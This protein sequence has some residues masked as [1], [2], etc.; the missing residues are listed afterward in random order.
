[1]GCLWVGKSCPLV[2]G[3]TLAVH[4]LS[5]TPKTAEDLPGS[6]LLWCEV[7]KHIAVVKEVASTITRAGA[8]IPGPCLLWALVVLG[9]HLPP[10]PH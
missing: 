1:M 8:A 7:S 10:L 3:S 6:L 9:F 2:Q 4:S 5:W